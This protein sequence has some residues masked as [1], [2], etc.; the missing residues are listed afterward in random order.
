[1]KRKTNISVQDNRGIRVTSNMIVGQKDEGFSS[2]DLLDANATLETVNQKIADLVN[3][4]PETLDTLG[5]ID[6][7]LG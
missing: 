6:E 2:G 1:M 5:E 7:V 3:L 4:A